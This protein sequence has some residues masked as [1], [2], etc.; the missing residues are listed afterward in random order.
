MARV[1]L[2]G[3]PK[4]TVQVAEKL[5]AAGHE[6]AMVLCPFPKPVGRK[7]ALTPSEIEVWADQN[8]IPVTRVNKDIFA[9]DYTLRSLLPTADLL[10]V[11]D[12]GFLVPGWLLRFPKHGSLNIHPSLLPRWRGATPVPFTL[13]FGDTE[14]GV[15][16]IQMNEKFDL[17]EI[18][19]QT[20]VH[21]A[22]SDTTPTLLERAFDAGA[23]LLVD[24]INPYLSEKILP[25]PQPKTSP[26]PTTP[27]LTKED[28]FV[29][30]ASLVGTGDEPAP[31]LSRYELS[32]TPGTIERMVRAL[33]PW[34]KVWTI[35]P[36]GKR[37]IIHSASLAG[38]KLVLENVQLEGKNP[39]TFAE[40]KNQIYSD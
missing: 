3:T 36:N 2:A 15:S 11:A 34:P 14:T 5:K 16:I 27:R 7:K 26:K 20:P 18:I 29:P 35:L 31:L 10:I 6:I 30:F 32:T 8:H 13:L 40:V 37:L 24:I 4:T 38:K 25:Q 39:S 21:I 23:S 12:F 19:T 28:G 1:L 33:K 17:G 9:D 22:S